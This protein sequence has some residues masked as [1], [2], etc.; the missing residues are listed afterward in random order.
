MSRD[1]APISQARAASFIPSF[2]TALLK[3]GAASR[4][5]KIVIAPRA[6]VAPQ[7]SALGLTICGKFAH[8]MSARIMRAP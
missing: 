2:Q 3:H 4:L 7:V 1:H 8:V 5:A 6:F